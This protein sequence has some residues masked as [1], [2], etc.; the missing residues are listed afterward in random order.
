MKSSLIAPCGMNCNICKAHL[1]EKNKCPGCRFFN[2]KEPVSIAR[3]K[4]KNCKKLKGKKFCFSCKTFPC[5]RLKHLDKRYRTKYS[6]SEIDNLK[7]IKEKGVKKFIDHEKKR[8][9]KANK[10]YCVHDKKYYEIR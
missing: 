6:M 10:V 4:I 3:C 9:I 8:W 7:F 1:R 2:A 5:E